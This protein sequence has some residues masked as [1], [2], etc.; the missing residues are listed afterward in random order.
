MMMFTIYSLQFT[1]QE[2]F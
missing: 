1:Q 2:N